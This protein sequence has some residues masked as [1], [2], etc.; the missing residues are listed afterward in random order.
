MGE[1]KNIISGMGHEGGLL[2]NPERATF[3][4]C[5]AA[6]KLFYP[7]LSLKGSLI[8]KIDAHKRIY[9]AWPKEPLCPVVAQILVAAHEISKEEIL[10][11]PTEIEKQTGDH[12]NG[13]HALVKFADPEREDAFLRKIVELINAHAVE[14]DKENNRLP[15]D[16]DSLCYR[17]RDISAKAAAENSKIGTKDS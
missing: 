2:L 5:D 3:A 8:K 11:K 6:L 10:Q 16:K 1:P 13:F 17:L 14:L 12:Q 7:E 15:T 9:I 4:Q